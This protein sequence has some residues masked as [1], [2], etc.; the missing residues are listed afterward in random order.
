MDSDL[1]VPGE[2]LDQDFFREYTAM[3]DLQANY[4]RI[5]LAHKVISSGRCNRYGVRI[6]V[7][8]N[9]NL[10]LMESLL[11]EYQDQD[12]IE[13]LRYGFPISRDENA[14][15]LILASINHK[16]ATWYP[17]HIDKYVQT[18]LEHKSTMGPFRIPQ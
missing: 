8:S 11:S 16:E 15:D 1:D 12:A 6:P 2:V 17:E 10:E 4:E 7:K 3:V 5:L 13:S 14:P 18:E 9:W